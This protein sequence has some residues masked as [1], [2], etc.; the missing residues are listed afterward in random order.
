MFSFESQWKSFCEQLTEVT[1]KRAFQSS[2]FS[3]HR[4]SPK[5]VRFLQCKVYQKRLLRYFTDSSQHRRVH[6]QLD[7]LATR[8]PREFPQGTV[9][10]GNALDGR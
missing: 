7:L 8:G 1:Q 4:I 3:N 5:V 10:D 9:T 6:A 2:A